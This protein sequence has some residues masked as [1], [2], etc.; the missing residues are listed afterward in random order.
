MSENIEG[1]KSF[2]NEHLVKLLWGISLYFLMNLSNDF[3]DVKTTL[4]A[5]LINQATME[6]RLGAVEGAT[7]Q[8]TQDVRDLREYHIKKE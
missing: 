2:I 3:K 6:T 7:K 4:Q 1:V 5:I 8:N